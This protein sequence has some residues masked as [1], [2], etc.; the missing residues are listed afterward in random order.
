[1]FDLIAKVL[2]QLL[3]II[4]NTIAFRNYGLSLV[5]FTILIKLALLPLTIKQLKSTAK[6][7]EIQPELQKIQQRYKNDK[8][9]LNQEMM[10]LYQE[11]GVNPA[12]G[13]LPMLFQLPILF[14]LF[15]V[16]R[17]P[18]TYMFG[19]TKEMLGNVIT[20]VMAINPNFFSS[21]S[22]PFLDQF[23]G[24][25]GDPVAVA[26]LFQ[27]NHYFEI[28][29]VDAVN[30][31]PKLVEDGTEMI[32]LTFMKIFNLG[33]VPTYNFQVIKEN[34]GVYI[35]ALILVLITVGTTFLSTK[36]SMAKSMQN[37]DANQKMAST[38]KTMMYFGPLM[39]L[40]ISFQAPLGL[41]FYWLLSNLVQ[42]AQQFFTDKY[43]HNKK[44]GE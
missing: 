9:K 4:Y 38:N 2:G 6:M 13:C 8:E 16:I 14:A 31:I 20:K 43:M 21:D 22:F 37:Q 42:I 27:K 11:K 23:E 15:Y 12:G 40:F 25:K 30:T 7:Q 32:N 3:Y 44:E 17:K 18:L 36:L 19:W 33:V 39:T 28:N 35:P 1:M 41:S 10:K 24:I 34:P 26:E 29:V 5:L